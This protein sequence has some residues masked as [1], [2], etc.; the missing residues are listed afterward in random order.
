MSISSDGLLEHVADI[1][2][3]ST[4]LKTYCADN[5]LYIAAGKAGLLVYNIN[6]PKQAVFVKK[7]ASHFA[8]NFAV[9]DQYLY[10]AAGK[11]RISIFKIDH[12]ESPVFSGSLVFAD[13]LHDLAVYQHRLYLATETGVSLYQ[14]ENPQR[15]QLNRQWTDFGSAEKLFPG[16]KHMYVSDSFSGFRIIDPSDEYLPEFI[17]LSI[18][19]RMVIEG[20]DYLYV[21]GA[22]QGLLIVEKELLS[23]RSVVETMNTSGSAHD[24]WVR[25]H[26]LYVA[27]ATGGT[28]LRNLADRSSPFISLS[29]HRSESFAAMNNLLFV[30][31]GRGGVEVFDV[32]SPEQPKFVTYWPGLQGWRLAVDGQYIVAS[33]GAFGIDFVDISDIYHP[34]IVDSIKDIHPLDVAMI[35]NTVYVV[36]KDNGLLIYKVMEGEQLKRVS[37]LMTPFPMNRFDLSIAIQVEDGTAYI[38]NGRAGLLIVDVTN[39]VKPIIL[40]SIS[41]PGIC[42]ELKVVNKR[43]YAVSHRG[44]VSV[45][46]VKDPVNPIVLNT[47]TIPGLSRGIESVDDSIYVSHNVM[48]VTKVPMPIVPDAVDVISRGEMRVELPS[49][50]S[51]GHYNLQISN[52]QGSIVIERSIFYKY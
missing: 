29:K 51:G 9:Q 11:D 26:W 50:H 12:P 38:A 41:V 48:G 32:S 16:E 43:I 10:L 46:D 23:L 37:Q 14:L 52:P 19:P 45:V 33:K 44:G 47:F 20:K 31:Q 1:I 28:L 27:D 5:Y 15:P 21:A 30:A 13:K 25:G 3:T 36:S 6:Q 42:K 7:I 8:S 40:S 39:P 49:P 4:V 18:N 17:N 2:L 22:D 35:G 24:L 34:V